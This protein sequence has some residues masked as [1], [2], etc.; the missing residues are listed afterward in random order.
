MLG[1]AL[2]IVLDREENLKNYGVF[3]DYLDRRESAL[4]QCNKNRYAQVKMHIG[5]SIVDDEV[6]CG[7]LKTFL[8]AGRQGH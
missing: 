1:S 3:D 2:P 7:P 4:V 6:V 5:L 8:V